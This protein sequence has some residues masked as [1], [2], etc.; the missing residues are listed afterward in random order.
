MKADDWSYPVKIGGT[1]KNITVNITGCTL[2]GANCIEN[3]GTS[4]T[5]NIT[6]CVLNSN[7]VNPSSYGH[8]IKDNGTGNVYNV[9]NTA[10]NGTNAA[11][12]SDTTDA[13]FNDLGGNADNTSR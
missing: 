1:S 5:V 6:D 4:C 12:H 7:Y 11:M 3:F 8:G 9:K 10:F 2:T 13:V